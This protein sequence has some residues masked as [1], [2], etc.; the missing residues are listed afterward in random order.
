M[1]TVM[2]PGEGANV[3]R[4]RSEE[5]RPLRLTTTLY[6]LLAALQDVVGPDDDPLV[7]ATMVHLLRSGRLTV[8]GTTST[9]GRSR[10]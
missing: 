10:R 4:G 7:V 2:E 5:A 8:R 6:D 3:A 9:R 1:S